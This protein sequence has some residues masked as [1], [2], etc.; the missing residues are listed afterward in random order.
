M[1]RVRTT[2]ILYVT[3][4]VLGAFGVDPSAIGERKNL[5]HDN[6]FDI[7]V[8][9][10]SSSESAERLSR[11]RTYQPINQPSARDDS[12]SID[13]LSFDVTL[14]G[15]ANNQ[16]VDTTL[17]ISTPF[18]DSCETPSSHSELWPVWKIDNKVREFRVKINRKSAKALDTPTLFLCVYN[19]YLGQLQ[20]LGERSALK[21]VDRY[22][23][24]KVQVAHFV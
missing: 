12:S 14:T 2:V 4:L 20:H 23:F 3:T 1:K 10:T 16:Q 7:S 15:A 17:L 6:I 8:T 19:E 18:K 22:D 11:L 21:L 9:T 13:S 24:L 5:E